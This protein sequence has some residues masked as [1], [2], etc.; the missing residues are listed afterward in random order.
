MR[1]R[2]KRR[3]L[4]D[5][6]AGLTLTEVILVVV[7]IGVLAT[8]ATLGFNRAIAHWELLTAARTLV[9]DIRETRDEALSSGEGAQ[10]WFYREWDYYERRR[11]GAVKEEVYLPDRVTF[12]FINGFHKLE[13]SPVASAVYELH[14]APSGN[15]SVT[16][17]V[18]VKNT[19]DEYRK[20]VVR[21][22]TGRVRLE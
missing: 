13:P 20:V 16:G 17:T 7:I 2:S 5:T 10:V 8:V 3:S 4:P 22:V 1:G 6:E 18:Y 19:M 21:P 9:S 12:A 15:P 11:G 14:F